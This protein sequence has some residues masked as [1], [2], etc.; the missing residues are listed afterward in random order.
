MSVNDH[1]FTLLFLTF[2]KAR[3]VGPVKNAFYKILSVLDNSVI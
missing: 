3:D 1:S 2:T